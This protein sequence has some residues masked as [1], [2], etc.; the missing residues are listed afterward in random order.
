MI[1]NYV[2]LGSLLRQ[3]VYFRP[4]NSLITIIEFNQYIVCRWSKTATSCSNVNS[5]QQLLTSAGPTVSTQECSCS[6]PQQIPSLNSSPS[7]RNAA[8]SMVSFPTIFNKT[9]VS[10]FFENQL[11]KKHYLKTELQQ[12]HPYL[13]SCNKL[14]ILM[15]NVTNTTQKYY[16]MCYFQLRMF[17]RISFGHQST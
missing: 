16:E 3:D 10:F 2:L 4:R 1:V 12:N 17:S 5:C 8:A 15:E 14:I 11:Q 13:R 9:N 7:H 6:P